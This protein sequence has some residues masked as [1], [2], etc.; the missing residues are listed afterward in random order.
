MPIWRVNFSLL[1]NA[2]A[3]RTAIHEI[4]VH[5]N[6]DPSECIDQMRSAFSFRDVLLQKEKFECDEDLSVKVF[7]DGKTHKHEGAERLLSTFLLSP[8]QA[9]PCER[10]FTVSVQL[11]QTFG[12]QATSSLL[13][14][15]MIVSLY[16]PS[17]DAAH[18]ILQECTTQFLQK[19]RR[20]S[21]LT[22]DMY[23][24]GRK[25]T[26]RKRSV[27]IVVRSAESITRPRRSMLS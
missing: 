8:G 20:Q 22:L 2:A 10:A 17:T 25:M 14:S 16:G 4:D 15:Y 23:R 9:S 19:E 27:K 6:L 18:H 26:V 1:N 5:L 11:R 24:H 7:V 12:S 3:A 21:L 13:F